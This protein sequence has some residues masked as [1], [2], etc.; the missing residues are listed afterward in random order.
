MSQ[1]FTPL[2]IKFWGGLNRAD[3]TRGV[4]EYPTRTFSDSVRL[5]GVSY[6][7]VELNSFLLAD[8]PYISHTQLAHVVRHSYPEIHFLRQ[9]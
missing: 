2:P 3:G 1:R 4:G 8:L 5:W 6:R 9:L 7:R